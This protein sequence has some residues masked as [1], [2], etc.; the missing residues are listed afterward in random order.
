LRGTGLNLPLFPDIFP[1]REAPIVTRDEAGKRSIGLMRRG[2]PKPPTVKGPPTV[3][4]VRNVSS[5]WRKPHLRTGHAA[6]GRCL[7]P[8]TFSTQ[9]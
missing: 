7:M 8:A 9:K 2:F 6:G 1:D 5:S 3:Q 4:N